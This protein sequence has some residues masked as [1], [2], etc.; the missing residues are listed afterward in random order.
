VISKQKAYEKLCRIFILHSCSFKAVSNVTGLTVGYVK[1]IIIELRNMGVD[2]ATGIPTKLLGYGKR[3]VNAVDVDRL[4]EI[5]RLTR[6][7]KRVN[8]KRTAILEDI[9]LLRAKKK[10]F[11]KFGCKPKEILC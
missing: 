6:E 10:R 11:D 4:N 1:R 8:N 9:S 5:V 2:V 3:I 7:I